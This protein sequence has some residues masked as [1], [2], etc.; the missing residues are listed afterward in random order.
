MSSRLESATDAFLRLRLGAER[1]DDLPLSTVQRA[2]R[3]A[4]YL[5]ADRSV[6]L[7]LKVLT[8]ARTSGV[9]RVLDEHRRRFDGAS[10]NGDEAASGARARD[11][12]ERRLFAAVA[13]SVVSCA[14][15]ANEQIAG[16]T[17]TFGLHAPL[18]VLVF[19]NERAELSE[20]RLVCAAAELALGARK[21]RGGRALPHLD[22]VLVVTTPADARGARA[23]HG[24][25]A[26]D[27]QYAERAASFARW[28]EG[29]WG[30]GP[31]W[32]GAGE[33]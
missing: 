1:I 5:L 18:G 20:P 31:E 12:L 4:D 29:E 11:E 26:D 19:A 30:S 25:S 28:F 2:A 16:T 10:S 17:R 32:P 6:V 14:E 13:K 23:V 9:R 33:R 22:L 21:E 27:S 24:V 3:K 8:D 7:E 15:S